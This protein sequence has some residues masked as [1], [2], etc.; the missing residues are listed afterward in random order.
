MPRLTGARLTS[1]YQNFLPLCQL[2]C[3][4]MSLAL[5]FHQG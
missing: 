4:F 5:T 2:A 3:Q 1:L